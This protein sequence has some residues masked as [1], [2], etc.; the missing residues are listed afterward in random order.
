MAFDLVDINEDKDRSK[1]MGFVKLAYGDEYNDD[2]EQ[3][4]IE[5]MKK[6]AHIYFIYQDGFIFG[7]FHIENF[8]YLRFLHCER[9]YKPTTTHN[10][11]LSYIISHFH[12]NDNPVYFDK[13]SKISML[14]MR[15]FGRPIYD[16]SVKALPDGELEY[17]H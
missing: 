17:L 14:Y 8:K 16:A 15:M 5:L 4:Y 1:F 2:L 12:N 7:A 9:I 6:P 13:K 11:A 3:Y 10:T